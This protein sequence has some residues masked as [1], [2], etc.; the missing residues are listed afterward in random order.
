MRG[1][2]DVLE[3]N[4]SQTAEVGHVME[5]FELRKLDLKSIGSSLEVQ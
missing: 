4:F 5:S 1:N 3:Y 2:P